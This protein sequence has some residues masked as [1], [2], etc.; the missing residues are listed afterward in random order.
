M[1]YF[2]L[3]LGLLFVFLEFYLP[4]GFFAVAGAIFVFASIITFFSASES[5]LAS[6]VFFVGSITALIVCIR[7]AIWRI[8]KSAGKDTFFLSKDQEG[9]KSQELEENVVGKKGVTITD[10]GPSGYALIDGKRYPVICRGPYLDKGA[11]VE[12]IAKE[13]GNYI[14]KLSR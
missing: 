1:P 11:Q 12:V 7:V 4:G 2:L 9:Y 6:A 8:K 13:L 14:V 5:I 3:F 10:C